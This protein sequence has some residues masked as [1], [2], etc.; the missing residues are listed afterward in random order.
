[1]ANEPVKDLIQREY[2]HGF[3]TEIESETFEPGLNEDIIRRLS[4][5]KNEPEFMLEWRLQAYRKW[6]TMDEPNW[7]HVDFPKVDYN[8]LSYYSAPKSKKDGPK[9]LDEVDPELLR[10]YEKLG[11]PLH[12]R[13]ALAGV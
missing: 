7:A 6:L 11:I 12:E 1:M 13:A 10:T 2:E 3:V 4:A 9:S 8:A 5:I